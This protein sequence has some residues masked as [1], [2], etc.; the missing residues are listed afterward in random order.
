MGGD[1]Q[2]LRQLFDLTQLLGLGH[3]IRRDIAHRDVAAL[4]HQ[5]ARQFAAHAR[6]APGDDRD[7]S[8]KILHGRSLTFPVPLKLPS[9]SSFVQT[10]TKGNA[11]EALATEASLSK[12]RDGVWFGD[13]GRRNCTAT[14]KILNHS[15]RTVTRTR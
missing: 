5:L 3:S 2:P 10:R 15:V 14:Q 9:V 8:G 4:G 13:R 7:L 11:A 6:A 1:A 12:R